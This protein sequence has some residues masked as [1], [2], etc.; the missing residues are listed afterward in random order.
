MAL[1]AD[2][3]NGPSAPRQKIGDSVTDSS[4]IRR[5]DESSDNVSTEERSGKGG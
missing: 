1:E 4:D 2:D 5:Q 3:N